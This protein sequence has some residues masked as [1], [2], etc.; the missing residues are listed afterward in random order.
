VIQT[1]CEHS[2]P[3]QIDLFCGV[4]ALYNF[5]KHVGDINVTVATISRDGCEHDSDKWVRRGNSVA[6]DSVQKLKLES[7][8]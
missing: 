2:I 1:G 5:G 7:S 8:L 4:I 3:T 6:S